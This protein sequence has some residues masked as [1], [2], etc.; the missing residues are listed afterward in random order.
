M[1]RSNG[2]FALVHRRNAG[3]L[4]SFDRVGQVSRADAE[5]VVT[6]VDQAAGVSTT[7]SGLGNSRMIRPAPPI[8]DV[9]IHPLR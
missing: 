2:D 8:L 5:H 9:P 3:D 6:R 4:F 1:T 7:T